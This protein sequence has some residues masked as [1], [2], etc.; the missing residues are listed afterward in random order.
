R[1]QRRRVGPTQ[2]ARITLVTSVEKTEAR[3]APYSEHIPLRPQGQCFHEA[4][5]SLMWPDSVPAA[6]FAPR[7]G[8]MLTRHERR[9]PYPLCHRARRSIRRRPTLTAGLRRV[10][11][12]GGRAAGAREAGADP[13][14]DGAGP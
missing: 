11:P 12:A 10:A 9:H 2:V 1:N 8:V 5:G 4:V 14:A 3:N 13:A 7:C 6:L